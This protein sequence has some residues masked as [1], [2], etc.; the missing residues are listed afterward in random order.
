MQ[1]NIN[2]KLTKVKSAPSVPL[3]WVLR[4]EL[5]ITGTK[6]GCGMAQ[7]GACTVHVD[8]T[9]VK[10]CITPVSTVAAKKI[11]TIEGASGPEINAL[12]AAWQELE[13]AQ[14]GYCQGGQILAATHLLSTNKNPSDRD[15]DEAMGGNICRCATY[16]RIKDGIKMASTA[17][18]GVK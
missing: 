7:C 10:S 18:R 5:G 9:P 11:V 2:G 4:D 6:F 14:C 16:N 8:G 15:I 13:V 17:L 1:L 3:L 12:R